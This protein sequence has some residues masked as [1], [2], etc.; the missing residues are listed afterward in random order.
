MATYVIG[1][2][3]GC[4]D[5]LQALL[6]QIDYR[7][8]T[9]H[10]WFVGDIVNRG[11]KSLE[12]LRFVK[13]LQQQGQAQ[14][15]LG[16]HDFH[17]LAAYSGLKRF[18]SKSD[19][20][21]P[22]F[23]AHDAP[24][25]I[26]WLRHQPLMV[27]HPVYEAVMVHAGIPPQWTISE[28]QSHAKEVEAHLQAEDWQTFVTEH[29]FGSEPNRWNDTLGGWE[30]IRYIVN[31]F[32]RMRYCD[33]DGE[34]EFKLKSAPGQH[35]TPY[36]PWFVF[37]NRKNKTHE[38]FFGHWSTLGEIDAYQVHATDTGCLWGGKL[39]AYCLETRKRHT[40]ACK[41]HSKP[42]KKKK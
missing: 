23:E 21:D 40:L 41:Q 42:K 6:Q 39:T 4:F 12:C 13:Q 9:D 27:S 38:I 11:P 18:Q 19:T 15:V 14:M 32:A 25:L 22:I 8:E 7:P 37:D 26:D 16:N 24:E 30:R 33:A 5:E 10:L 2:L 20:L 1:D 3:Q 36:Q 35:D 29:L 17:L 28:A 34:L 31:A